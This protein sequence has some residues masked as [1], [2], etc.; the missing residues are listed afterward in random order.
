MGD[1]QGG[2]VCTGCY[3][4]ESGPYYLAVV[5]Q[6]QL[7]LVIEDLVDPIQFAELAE[8]CGHSV[9]DCFLSLSC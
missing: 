9:G 3:F 7:S 4:R 5:K 2:D 6:V 8:T 1:V